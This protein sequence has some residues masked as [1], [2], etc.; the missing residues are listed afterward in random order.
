MT[1]PSAYRIS[2]NDGVARFMNAVP[3]PELIYDR[4]SGVNVLEL[5][6]VP[7]NIR[8]EL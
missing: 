4:W 7:E 1:R 3:H 6:H 5:G 8:D 2:V